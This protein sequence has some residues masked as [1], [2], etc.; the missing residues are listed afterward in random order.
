VLT[1]ATRGDG[2]L[3]AADAPVPEPGAGEL[4]V[5]VEACGVC[6]TD[7]HIV[8]G[9]LSPH[10]SPV[11]PGHEVVGIV[12]D[13]GDGVEGWQ[14]G[15]RAG[16]A[17]LRHTCG[18]CEL[19]VRGDENLCRAARFTGWDAD[20][21]YAEYAVAPADFAYRLPANL[22]AV[23]LAPLLCAGIIGY[24]ALRRSRLPAGGALGVWGFGGSAHIAAQVAVHEGGRVHAFTRGVA[25]RELALELGAVSANDSF[26][27][28]PEPLDAAILFAP[29][30]DLVP[31]AL[32]ALAPGATLA[33]AGIHL[34]DIPTLTY[35]EHLFDERTLTSV[36]ANTRQDGRQLLALADV[37]R[38]HTVAY[39]LD[40]ADVALDDLRHDRF[41]GAAVLASNV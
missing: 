17:W 22:D 10:R 23:A 7:L 37:I 41:A 8:D 34:S 30:G 4:R 40:R 9:D 33:V 19:C 31:A 36:T 35:R 2:R 5:R 11:V 20:G 28:S 27:P 15:D 38:V 13:F 14:R 3:V 25:A 39:P 12:D 18:V 1:W 26:D 24:R 16:I 29:V 21:G 6:R 32:A